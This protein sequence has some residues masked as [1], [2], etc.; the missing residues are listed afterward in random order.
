[1][2][3]IPDKKDS[4]LCLTETVNM[5]TVRRLTETRHLLISLQVGTYWSEDWIFEHK[6]REYC[7]QVNKK[8]SKPE[9]YWIQSLHRYLS[10]DSAIEIRLY[11][12][13]H[14][15]KQTISAWYFQ[16]RKSII[17]PSIIFLQDNKVLYFSLYP[18]YLVQ[19]AH[20]CHCCFENCW[21]SFCSHWSFHWPHHL[22]PNLSF[23]AL[24]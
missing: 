16:S 20:W 18:N 22:N 23:I 8:N 15:L 12:S 11:K 24:P 9:R 6:A 5:N 13:K 19:C 7:S 1:M 3:D 14:T 4:D 21:G 17:L 2:I 10:P